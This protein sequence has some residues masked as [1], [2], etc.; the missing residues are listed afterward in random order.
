LF[1]QLSSTYITIVL[2]KDENTVKM[3]ILQEDGHLMSNTKNE[4]IK[5][6][7]YLPMRRR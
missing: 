5:Y 4:W 1:H 2:K 7:I 6:E 3:P